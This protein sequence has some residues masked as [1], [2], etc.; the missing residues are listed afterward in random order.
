MFDP[1]M[2]DRITLIS[3]AGQRFEDLPAVV[4]G[5]SISVD[6]RPGLVVREGD[7][8]E[9]RLS[10]GVLERYVVV[11]ADFSESFHGMPAFYDLTV[12]KEVA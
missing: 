8:V 6:A 5:R 2:T 7:R 4:E 9:R 12:Q 1:L 3:Q 10:N 11:S